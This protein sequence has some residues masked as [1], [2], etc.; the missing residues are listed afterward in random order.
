MKMVPRSFAYQA[1]D[2]ISPFVAQP[3]G[4]DYRRLDTV[5]T[6]PGGA[7]LGPHA[8][9]IEPGLLGGGNAV[10]IKSAEIYF[11]R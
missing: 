6:V 3:L 2:E 5:W 10:D 8:L 7:G 9:L 1:G 4:E 11:T